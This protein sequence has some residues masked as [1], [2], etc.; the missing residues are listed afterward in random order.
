MDL[1]GPSIDVKLKERKKERKK[2]K[3]LQ[4]STPKKKTNSTKKTLLKRKRNLKKEKE[5]PQNL[6]VGYIK[7]MRSSVLTD[8][9]LVKNT[10]KTTLVFIHYSPRKVKIH[11]TLTSCSR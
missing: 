10:T 4:T 5:K 1:S 8:P 2:R 7:G 3:N 9:P 11:A 6:Q